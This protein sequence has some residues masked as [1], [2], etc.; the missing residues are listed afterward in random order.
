MVKFSKE[1]FVDFTT[2]VYNI[3]P[4]DDKTSITFSLVDKLDN[5]IKIY[6]STINVQCSYCCLNDL[7][8]IIFL[9]N[10]CILI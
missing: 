8:A 10:I 4:D 1:M 3:Q 9:T 7:K 5:H 2:V 6:E